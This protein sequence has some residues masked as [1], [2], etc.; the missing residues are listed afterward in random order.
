MHD[1]H[2]ALILKEATAG[3]L[4]ET[5]I[6]WKVRDFL[7]YD[8]CGYVIAG[9]SEY[10]NRELFARF[11]PAYHE[12]KGGGASPKRINHPLGVVHHSTGVYFRSRAD[13]LVPRA[14]S[15]SS[16]TSVFATLPF[17]SVF[18]ALV[19]FFFADGSRSSSSESAGFFRDFLGSSK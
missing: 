7:R 9:K 4:G 6:R 1:G 10:I 16:V 13:L 3:W 18:T 12:P 5:V 17:F 8:V 14:G 19:R 11:W 15:A 2:Y